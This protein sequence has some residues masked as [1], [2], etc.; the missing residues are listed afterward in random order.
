MRRG[1][2]MRKKIK[3]RKEEDKETGQPQAK[4]RLVTL[5]AKFLYNG[6]Q[7]N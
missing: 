2:R 7:E 5:V 1:D 3:G 6:Y 4:S